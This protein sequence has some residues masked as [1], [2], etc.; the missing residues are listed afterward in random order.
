MAGLAPHRC[1]EASS[2]LKMEAAQKPERKQ[3]NQYQAQNA[4]KPGSAIAPI[5]VVA[6]TSAEQQE[7]HDNYH[8]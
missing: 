2:A 7:E 1:C 5:T 6:T 8:N 4:P 3:D